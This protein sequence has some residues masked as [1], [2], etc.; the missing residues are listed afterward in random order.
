M[1]LF[2][3]L[4]ENIE[5]SHNLFVFHENTSPWAS[6]TFQWSFHNFSQKF[7]VILSES[8]ML[9]EQLL[10]LF[11]EALRI[12]QKKIIEHTTEAIEIYN[13]VL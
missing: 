11:S 4:L 9:A 7:F 2:E 10:E 12:S 5:Y 8:H 6:Q 3:P 13:G 1:N